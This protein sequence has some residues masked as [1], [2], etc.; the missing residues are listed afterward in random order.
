VAEYADSPHLVSVFPSVKEN[1][2]S[3]NSTLKGLKGREL[4]N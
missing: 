1:V 2:A 4:R 3:V